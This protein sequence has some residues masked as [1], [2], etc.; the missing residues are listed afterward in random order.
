MPPPRPAG[1]AKLMGPSMLAYLCAER[2]ASDIKE[3]IKEELHIKREQMTT[4]ATPALAE[5]R[6]KMAFAD[7]ARESCRSL[8]PD[9]QAAC[10]ERLR[11]AYY[12][13]P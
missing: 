5:A 4:S 11:K 1:P 12:G 6:L 13:S 7:M 9:Q 2:F 8:Q 3:F 10:V